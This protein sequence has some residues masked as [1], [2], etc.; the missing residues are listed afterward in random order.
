MFL[1]VP[2]FPEPAHRFRF[3]TTATLFSYYSFSSSRSRS[4][5]K[6]GN[7]RHN[8]TGSG[9]VRGADFR[10]PGL[11]ESQKSETGSLRPASSPVSPPYKQRRRKQ[12][13]K[14]AARSGKSGSVRKRRASAHTLP[15]T[16][17]SLS[18]ACTIRGQEAVSSWKM[19]P[20][21]PL[22]LKPLPWGRS[23]CFSPRNRQTPRCERWRHRHSR[24][25]REPSGR[26]IPGRCSGGS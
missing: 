18:A 3:E 16:G 4:W 17:N 13:W 15:C 10:K 2:R 24:S 20:H 19:R 1:C 22:H 5:R 8:R 7:A 9:W 23:R 6:S 11:W 26:R 14:G 21:R 12:V 25:A